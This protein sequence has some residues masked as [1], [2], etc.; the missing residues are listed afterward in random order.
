[1][2]HWKM[3]IFS[4]FLSSNP[5]DCIWDI[6][7]CIYF[8]AFCL[9]ILQIV[10]ETLKNVYIFRLSVYQSYILYTRHWKM[11][12]FSGFLSTNLTDCIWDIERCIY[13]QAF[14]LPILQIVY[15]T[16]KDVYIFRL[17]VYQ[18]Y[19]LYMRHWKM[20]I[21]SGFL[22]TSPTDCIWDIERCIYFQAFCLPILQIVY[23]TLKDQEEG[24]GSKVSAKAA[25]G[26]ELS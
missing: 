16:L 25:K 20:Y 10:Y 4:G 12:I 11:Y 26:M 8:Q 3:Y 24:K 15:E 19:R 5:T 17:S 7:R 22:S 23:E 6:E 2:R 21:F 9:T 1:M 13:F 18:S 14:C